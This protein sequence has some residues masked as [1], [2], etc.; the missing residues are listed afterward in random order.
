MISWEEPLQIFIIFLLTQRQVMWI[1]LDL[2]LLGRFAVSK[3]WVEIYS[4]EKLDLLG[5]L[6]KYHYKIYSRSVFRTQPNI[7]DK[8]FLRK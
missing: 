4:P 1:I 8:T 3:G 2:Y 5:V 6:Y 7:Y